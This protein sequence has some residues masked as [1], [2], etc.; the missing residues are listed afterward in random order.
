MIN[1][2]TIATKLSS[3]L[4]RIDHGVPAAA[5][6]A[7]HQQTSNTTTI[8][9]NAMTDRSANANDEFIVQQYQ[10]L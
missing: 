9:A 5:M 1:L 7:N 4:Q 6:N 2:R 10:L 3:L 8:S